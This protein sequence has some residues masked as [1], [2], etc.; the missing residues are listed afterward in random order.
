[1]AIP[2]SDVQ[3]HFGAGTAEMHVRNLALDDYGKIPTALGPQWQ[4]AFDPAIVSFDVVWSGPITR[5]VS[6]TNGR[7]WRLIGCVISNE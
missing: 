2:D 6:V 4:T 3:V 7:S 5:A 1:M